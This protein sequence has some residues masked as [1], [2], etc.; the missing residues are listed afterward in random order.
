MGGFFMREGL[1]V[2]WMCPNTH[3]VSECGRGFEMPPA[4]R[5]SLCT[6]ISCSLLCLR[7]CFLCR[8]GR[9]TVCK[10]FPWVAPLILIKGEEVDLEGWVNL[11]KAAQLR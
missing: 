10:D 11:A 2:P 6:S 5:V 1:G 3:G 8:C 9:H 4:P 7:H